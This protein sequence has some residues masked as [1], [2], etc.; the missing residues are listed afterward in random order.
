MNADEWLAEGRRLEEEARLANDQ[1]QRRANSPQQPFMYMPQMMPMMPQYL[2]REYNL[3]PPE[4]DT[5]LD[6]K[7]LPPLPMIEGSVPMD[8]I[9]AI[10]KDRAKIRKW[11]GYQLRTVFLEHLSGKYRDSFYTMANKDDLALEEITIVC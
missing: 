3:N 2:P 6:T 5:R 4:N 7:D 8:T 9:F 10:Y 1:H 11:N